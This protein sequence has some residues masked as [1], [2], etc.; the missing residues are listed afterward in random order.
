MHGQGGLTSARA[1]ARRAD[2]VADGGDVGA[3]GGRDASGAPRFDQPVAAGGYLW[4]YVDAI[5][6]DGRH[7]LTLI[8]FVGS[9]F[10]PY[11]A[12]ARWRGGGSADPEN[13]VALN[14]A[15]YGEGGKRWTMTERARRHG[16][17]TEGEFTIGPSGLS[18][19][20]QSLTVEI[21]EVGMFAPGNPE[22]GAFLEVTN[23]S[24]YAEAHAFP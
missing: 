20:G 24:R 1:L 22:G 3:S 2:E 23:R 17:R 7:A 21:D 18:W 11:Y 6:D 15:L 16:R 5:S 19:D 4:W 9:V 10:S 8:A 12:L 14:V 13:H